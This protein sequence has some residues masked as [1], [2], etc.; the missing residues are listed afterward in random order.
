MAEEGIDIERLREH[1]RP[2][3]VCR[4]VLDLDDAESFEL[5]DFEEAPV[6]VTRPVASLTRASNWLGVALSGSG[7]A[8]IYATC[9]R[10]R[11]ASPSE[12]SVPPNVSSARNIAPPSS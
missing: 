11:F 3:V 7:F 2:V 6:D 4:D 12:S 9:A 10:A 1:I 5:A 8:R